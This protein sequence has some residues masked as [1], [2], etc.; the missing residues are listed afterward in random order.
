MGT[1]AT[2]SCIFTVIAIMDSNSITRAIE[3]TLLSSSASKIIKYNGPVSLT[4]VSISKRC[5]T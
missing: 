1:C 3:Q 4:K 5:G 2:D